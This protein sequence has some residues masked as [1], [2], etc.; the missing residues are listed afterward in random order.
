MKLIELR[1]RFAVVRT[2]PIRKMADREL[3]WLESNQRPRTHL[4]TVLTR[5]D[6]HHTL[7]PNERL[8]MLW[9]GE[10]DTRPGDSSL[11]GLFETFVAEKNACPIMSRGIPSPPRCGLEEDVKLGEVRKLFSVH[12]EVAP[13][14][15]R[16]LHLI[17]PGSVTSYCGKLH[18]AGRRLTHLY[19]TS[20]SEFTS[21]VFACPLCDEASDYAR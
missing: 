20:V 12:R 14:E 15:T 21:D 8:P 1:R 9:C 17:R 7:S 3:A 13:E 11:F 5:A 18:E 6:I 2:K 19:T 4:A 16:V 10:M